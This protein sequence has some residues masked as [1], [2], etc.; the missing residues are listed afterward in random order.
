M[1]SLSSSATTTHPLPLPCPTICTSPSSSNACTAE[2]WNERLRI[3]FVFV[4]PSSLP[5]N[6]C[7]CQDRRPPCTCN[8]H[9]H[10]DPPKPKHRSQQGCP[11]TRIQNFK[12]VLDPI[13]FRN[14][15]IRSLS[16]WTWLSVM[17]VA[18]AKLSRDKNWTK[19]VR[20]SLQVQETSL[21]ASSF[22][23]SASLRYAVADP[24][25][26][27][28]PNPKLCHDPAWIYFW[29]LVSELPCCQG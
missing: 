3:F 15:F 8:P 2:T 21:H 18:S 10:W 28:Q 22:R 7:C 4:Y 29:L 26:Q 20:K 12:E 9:P 13:S 6:H 11:Q 23:D 27:L 5:F 19:L 17:I 1:R 14:I 24:R 25:Q 16:D